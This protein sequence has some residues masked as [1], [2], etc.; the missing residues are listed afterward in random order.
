M[1]QD[2]IAFPYLRPSSGIECS[3]WSYRLESDETY[4]PLLGDIPDWDYQ[5]DLLVHR[6]I[7]IEA[8]AIFSQIGLAGP[9]SEIA[10]CTT[11]VAGSTKKVSRVLGIERVPVNGAAKLKLNYRIGSADLSGQFNLETELVLI[12]A[13]NGAGGLSPS[14]PGSRLW[15]DRV[16]VDLEGTLSRFPMEV[17][18]FT[19]IFSDKSLE[20]AAWYLSWTPEDPDASFLGAVRVL[21]NSKRKSHLQRI[22]GCDADTLSGLLS[23]T[24]GQIVSEL[25]LNED[26]RNRFPDFPE[27][28]LGGVVSA[29]LQNAYPDLDADSILKRIDANPS[30]FRSRL[31]SMMVLNDG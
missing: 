30:R 8:D 3:N 11:L 6:E 19:D 20:D 9:A 14:I 26:F 12:H 22:E 28:S 25:L 15:A 17:C 23:D 24:A 16:S 18:D 13:G 1:R 27:E 2:Q 31:Q 21:V 10:L 5:N 29:W 7:E 4:S